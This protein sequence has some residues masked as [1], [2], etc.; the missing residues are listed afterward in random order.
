MPKGEPTRTIRLPIWLLDQLAEQAGGADGVAALITRRLAPQRAV[1][2]PGAARVERCTC[3][4]PTL[5]KIVT[6]LCTACGL[7]R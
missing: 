2:A 5:S 6:N 4:R 7:L 3:E 1:T